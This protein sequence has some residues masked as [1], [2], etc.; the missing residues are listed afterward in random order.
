MEDITVVVDGEYL[1][2]TNNYE[3]DSKIDVI[4]DVSHRIQS[5]KKDSY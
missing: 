4:M 1:V 3:H 2:F 5:K